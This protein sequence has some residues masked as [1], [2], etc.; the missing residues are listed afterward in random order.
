MA[1]DLVIR[2]ATVD[3]A[4]VIVHHRHAMFFD[5]GHTDPA[6]LAAMDAS[7]AP[8][9]ARGLRDGSYRGWLAQTD[10]GRV[11]AG[12]GLIVHEWPARPFSPAQP[13]RAY[14]LNVY[15]EPEFRRRGIA[16]R[17]M[18]EIVTWCRAQG[19]WAVML[20]ASEFGRPLYESMG[21]EPTNE[22]RLKLI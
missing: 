8:Y 2:A 21:F 18:A 16:R 17:I 7:F 3:D 6:A 10:D 13:R 19:F 12:G 14:I 9:V 22:M 15:T 5:M 11:V 4:A 20:H 1:A